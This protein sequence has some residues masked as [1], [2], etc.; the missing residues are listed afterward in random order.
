MANK[1]NVAAEEVVDV[2]VAGLGPTGLVLS[3]MLGMRGHR[4][5]V[6]EKEPKFYGNARAVY[7]DDEC[8]RVF[9]HLGV[10][11]LL[12]KDMLLET[13][14]QLTRPDCSVIGQYYPLERPFG[15]P[16][17]NFFY[18]PYLETKLTEQL[19]RYPNVEIRRGRELVGFE[20]D[21]SGVTV[22]HEAA[23]TYRYSDASD[24]KGERAG[25]ADIQTLRARYL[26]GADGGRSKVRELLGIKM[27]GKNFPEPWLVVDLKL[28][29]GA[30]ALRHIPYFNFII[31]AEMPAVSCVQPDGYHRFEF[32]MMQGQTKEWLERD[33]TVR[34]LLSKYVDPDQF[35]V[36][37]KLVYTFNALVANEW[38][39]GRV[40]LAGD[41]A[42]MTPQFMGQGASSGVRDGF[43]LG[44]K[45]G[46][47]LNGNAGDALLDSYER[48][49][50]DHAKAMIDASV[51]LKNVVSMT[52]PVGTMLR[53]LAFKGAMAIPPLRDYLQ[54]GGWKPA[55]IYTKGQYLGLPRRNG[56]G[57]EGSMLPQPEVRRIDG[58][59]VFLDEVLGTEYALVGLGVDPR[60]ELSGESR[61]LLER[62]GVRYVTLFAY[63][64]RPQGLKGVARETALGLV[65]VE[66]IG[67]RM[68]EW[69]RKA[70]HRQGAVAIVRPDKFTFGVTATDDVNNAVGELARQL[71]AGALA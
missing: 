14:V 1:K 34:M 65:E 10:A 49:R 26:V 25:D 17:V 28:K 64:H 69:F 30:D 15:W 70:G 66:D 35:E 68:V 46:A 5:V 21:A 8:M 24:V 27:T 22:T 53:D 50:R 52:S 6:L 47:V 23:T 59:R 43:N 11:D 71:N 39:K 48:E 41:A 51:M 62:L 18:Q 4:V 33:D 32:M 3:H 63:G 7:T 9:Q 40:F 29:P 20:Q 31:D 16:V 2:V 67:G 44:W 37:R 56:K 13:P 12:Q 38:R 55:P 19:A 45:L 42:H 57:P 58:R 54:T 36:K 61:R 60:D